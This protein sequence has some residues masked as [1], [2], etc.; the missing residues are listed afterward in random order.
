MSYAQY[1]RVAF[2][3]ELS[4]A[5]SDSGNVY[6]AVDELNRALNE[7]LLCW[8]ALTTYWTSRG[9]FSTVA[10]TP[11]YDLSAKLPTL[12]TRAYTFNE[13]TREIQYHLLEPSNG[14]PG[15]SMTDQFTIGQITAALERRRNQFVIDSRI[16]LTFATVN[17]PAPSISTVVLSDDVALITRAAWRDGVTGIVTPLRRSDTFGAQS[18]DPVW[19][20]SPGLPH[21]YSQAEAM[22]GTMIL[23]PPP[24]ASGS[25]HLTYAQ[26]L[27]LT[28]AAGTSFAV[29]DEFAWGLKYGALEEVLATNSQGYDPIR[30]RYCTERYKAA[31]EAAALHRSVLHVESNGTP[32][33]L[34]TLAEL[35]SGRPYWQTGSGAPQAAACAYDLLAFYKVP[36]T[37]YSIVC[38]VAQAAPLPTSDA[39]YIQVGREE[40]PYIFDYCRHILMLKIGGTEFIQSMP[41]YDNFLKGAMQRNQLLAAKARYLTPLFTV[42]ERQEAQ[43]NAA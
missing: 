14:V 4:Q 34:A 16:P 22:P 38:D 2:T 13:L 28:V 40:L 8:G 21:S 10:S 29:P 20:V 32:L 39:S 9:S 12:R 26:T 1:T 23:I 33:P 24:L 42:P 41:L 19:N 37:V 36:S 35:D 15:T 27:D 11:F 30:S 31:T 18:Y 43:S 3:T 25:I 17:G 7:A 6:W 5:L